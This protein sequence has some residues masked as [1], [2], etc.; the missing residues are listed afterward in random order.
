MKRL[1][2]PDSETFA[3]AIQDEISRNPQGRYFHR[4]HVVLQVLKGYSTYEAAKFYA[5]SPRTVQYWVQRLLSEG[6]MGLWDVDRPGRPGRLSLKEQNKLRKELHKSPGAL[7]YDQNIWD[8]PL[9]AHHLKDRYRINLGVRQCQRL[10]R[11]L[12]FSLQRPQPKAAEADP[13]EQ[14]RFKKTSIE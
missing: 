12:G 4:L 11:Q 2:I 14:E 8:G 6:L 10:F 3:A 7:K 9:L 1:V 5:H 13:L